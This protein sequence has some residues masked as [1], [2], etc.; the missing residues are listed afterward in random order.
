LKWFLIVFFQHSRIYY[1]T[2][3][4]LEKHPKYLLNLSVAVLHSTDQNSVADVSLTLL[5]D[6]TNMLVSGS[7][8]GRRRPNEGLIEIM[9]GSVDFCDVPRSIFGRVL[10]KINKEPLRTHSNLKLE[11][12]LK[13]GFYYISKFPMADSP[14]LPAFFPKMNL[15]LDLRAE[16]KTRVKN[17]R[18]MI[19]LCR[20]KL[21]GTIY[22]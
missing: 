13:K 21:N 17:T 11:C 14:E 1:D 9:K 5:E 10:L 19:T 4:I 18:S 8:K 12:P 16:V 7:L 2:I 6:L 15:T 3:E 22:W 20:F